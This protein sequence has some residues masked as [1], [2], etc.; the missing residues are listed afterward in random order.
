MVALLYKTGITGGG[1]YDGFAAAM[2]PDQG[3][4]SDILSHSPHASIE[5]PALASKPSEQ[6]HGGVLLMV[7]EAKDFQLRFTQCTLNHG[8]HVEPAPWLQLSRTLYGYAPINI[9][10]F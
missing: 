4:G 6:T 7:T 1:N 10:E 5:S 2:R 8:L 9:D 3:H